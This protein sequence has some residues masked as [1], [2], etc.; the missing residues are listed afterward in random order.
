MVMPNQARARLDGYRALFDPNFLPPA[1]VGRNHE[2]GLVCGFLKDNLCLKTDAVSSVPSTTSLPGAGLAIMIGG[3]NGVGKSTLARVV[4]EDISGKAGEIGIERSHI[5]NLVLNCV[6]KNETQLIL[7]LLYELELKLGVIHSV[8][9]DG[10]A[11]AASIPQA[12]VPAFPCVEDGIGEVHRLA[13]F[14]PVPELPCVSPPFSSQ[15]VEEIDVQAA[16]GHISRLLHTRGKE[17]F[18]NV[19]LKDIEYIPARFLTKMASNLKS[20][21]SNIL[22]TTSIKYNP[23][24]H[25]L[26]D[27]RFDLDVYPVST[28]EDIV[29]QR[30]RLAFRS[31]DASITRFLT[32]AVVEF[33][34]ARPGPCV[35]MLKKIFPHVAG[36][37]LEDI[38]LE[39]LQESVRATLPSMSYNELDLADYFN[40][41]TVQALVFIDNIVSHY[42]STRQPYVS[43]NQLRE[44]YNIS[45]E[46]MDLKGNNNEFE[47]FLADLR[48]NNL[49]LKSNHEGGTFFMVVP[50]RY[51]KVYLDEVLA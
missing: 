45:C 14:A 28:L 15:R 8:P 20:L 10:A 36:K 33:D 49:L 18:Y 3:F 47:S 16:W 35:A 31:V 17:K 39:L 9:V 25:D 22:M 40:T 43:R 21:G 44:I 29:E 42:A 5:V 27:V 41:A 46:S 1:L 37:G 24:I 34:S 7:D 26:V 12:R 32:D 4:L 2:R 48:G 50:P 6:E 19:L 13:R 11:T 30:A 51:L 23:F 38:D